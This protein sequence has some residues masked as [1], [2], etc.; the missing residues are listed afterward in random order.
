MAR[1]FGSQL[2]PVCRANWEVSRLLLLEF[3]PKLQHGRLSTECR[4]DLHTLGR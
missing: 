1:A 3:G 2:L 4:P